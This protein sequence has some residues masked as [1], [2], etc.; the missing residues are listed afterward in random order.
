MLL[1]LLG[2]IDAQRSSVLKHRV[3]FRLRLPTESICSFQKSWGCP[4]SGLS[5]ACFQKNIGF[6]RLLLKTDPCGQAV[7]GFPI[8]YDLIGRE[9]RVRISN[10]N[11]D[12]D[13]FGF[14]NPCHLAN[15]FRI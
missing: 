3:I 11:G 2:K 1:R 5:P 8:G 15:D 13:P 7:R 9:I 6:R 10:D 14:R 4:F 12:D